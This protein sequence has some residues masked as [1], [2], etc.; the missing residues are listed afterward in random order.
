MGLKDKE[1]W[2]SRQLISYLND[3]ISTGFTQNLEVE[4]LATIS[5]KKFEMY[6]AKNNFIK[7]LIYGTTT[8]NI[9]NVEQHVKY[10]Q[11][12]QMATGSMGHGHAAEY[13][14]HV[15]DKMCHP[16]KKVELV[17]QNNAKN[18]ADRIVGN[19]LIQTKYHNTASSTV[20]SAFE[21][22]S[23]GGMYRYKG[24]QLE[25]PRD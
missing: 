4:D 5:D 25:V 2:K 14:N 6:I 10:I 16:F 21:P 13:A 11:I 3:L 20:N 12:N 18:G 9:S 22:A 19:Q 1:E 8:V 15:K 17:G 23:K 24:M 7:G